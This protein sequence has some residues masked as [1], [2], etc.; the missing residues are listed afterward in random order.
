[1]NL[2]LLGTRGHNFKRNGLGHM[3]MIAALSIYEG[4]SICYDNVPITLNV[5]Y[6]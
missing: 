6:S 5:S 3:F 4:G 2:L 1:M